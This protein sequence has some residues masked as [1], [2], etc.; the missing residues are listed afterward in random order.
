[1]PVTWVA[2]RMVPSTP[3]RILYRF[4]HCWL[5]CPAR[6]AVTAWWVWRGR[7][8]SCRPER[9]ER[10]HRSRAGQGAQVLLA[11]LTTMVSVPR[12]R[13]GFQEM[14][15]APWGQVACWWSKSMVNAWVV[16][17]PV[18]ACGEV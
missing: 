4:F 15:V 10:V 3:A 7:R 17:P 1:M 14:L 9:L 5:V 16:Y 11:N 18:R 8:D 6:A 13:Q 2:W 12:W